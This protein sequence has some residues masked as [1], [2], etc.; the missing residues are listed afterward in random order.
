MNPLYVAS[1]KFVAEARNI[2]SIP[3]AIGCAADARSHGDR[4]LAAA[5]LGLAV[6]KWGASSGAAVPAG[7]REAAVAFLA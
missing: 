2:N 4:A 5:A 1:A 3:E 6:E 7:N